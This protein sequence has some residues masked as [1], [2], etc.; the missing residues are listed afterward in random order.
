MLGLRGVT[1][2]TVSLFRPSVDQCFISIAL[3]GPNKRARRAKG[4]T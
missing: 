2:L 3:M 1:I 4:E